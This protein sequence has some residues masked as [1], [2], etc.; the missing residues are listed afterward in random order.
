MSSHETRFIRRMIR[1]YKLPSNV[2]TSTRNKDS[3]FCPKESYDSVTRICPPAGTFNI[4]ACKFGSP[5]ILSFPHFYS[6]DESLFQKIE[7]LTP[8]QD[9]HES[10]VELHTVSVATHPYI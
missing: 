1:R 6:G 7:G 9:R 5:L 10:Y 4:S 8:R 2:F 3:C